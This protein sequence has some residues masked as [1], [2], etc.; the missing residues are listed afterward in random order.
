MHEVPLRVGV[1]AAP[2]GEPLGV[3]SG[4]GEHLGAHEDEHGGEAVVEEPEEVHDAGE[5]E[6]E[7][8]QAEDR[9]HVRR[10]GDKPHVGRALLDDAEDGRH[11]VDGEEHVGALDHEK[12][13]E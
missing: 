5:Q 1:P 10:E 8:A 6:V 13:E 12:D 4:L 11:A 2:L 3:P 9:E 7:G